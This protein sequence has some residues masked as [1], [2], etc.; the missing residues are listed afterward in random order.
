ME[1]PMKKNLSGWP[2]KE[3]RL[4][5][6]NYVHA[7]GQAALGYNLAEQVFEQIFC[8]IVPLSINNAQR[9]FHS[10]N[11]R[12]RIDLVC[13]LSRNN[14]HNKKVRESILFA[15]HYYDVCTENR[16]IIL[17]S[18]GYGSRKKPIGL[19]LTKVA[20]KDPTRIIEFHLSLS[21]IRLVAD[22]MYEGFLYMW[23]LYGFLEG[24]YRKYA[25][26]SVLFPN[27]SLPDKLLKPRKLTP[28]Q[29][30]KDHIDG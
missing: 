11:N 5:S 20:S 24:R 12:D 13:S 1:T 30:P 8:L 9:W 6:V 26:T 16:N 27:A 7:I 29:P 19:K 21:E 22:Q 23:R 14:E 10:L 3:A 17:H 25:T 18:V 4:A 15:M 2:R 28:Y